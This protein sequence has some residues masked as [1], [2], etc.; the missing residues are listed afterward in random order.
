M[1]NGKEKS[2]KASIDMLPLLRERNISST[3]FIRA[4][5]VLWPGQYAD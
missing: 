3:T 1:L 4:A 5:T 2:S